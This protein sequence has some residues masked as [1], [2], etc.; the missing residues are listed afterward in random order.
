MIALLI[1]RF[2][3]VDKHYIHSSFSSSEMWIYTIVNLRDTNDR[4]NITDY[5]GTFIRQDT[6]VLK[7]KQQG[8]VAYVGLRHG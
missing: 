2:I 6:V 8:L 7:E 5:D 3:I 1:V 4:R